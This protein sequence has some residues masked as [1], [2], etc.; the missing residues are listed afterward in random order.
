M[1]LVVVD[2]SAAFDTVDHE[3]LLVILRS[4]FCIDG[5]PLTWIK[6]YLNERSFQVQVG[7]TLSEPIGIPMPYHRGAYWALFFSSVILQHWKI[8]YKT[9]PH[10][11][12]AMQMIMQFIMAS[13]QWMNIW[14]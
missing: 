9:P 8:S 12:L 6:S 3:L 14:F 1:A 10:L 4:C 2:L 11:Y 5:I 13:Y 7:S